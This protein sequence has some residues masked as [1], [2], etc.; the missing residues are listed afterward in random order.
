LTRNRMAFGALYITCLAA[1]LPLSLAQAPAQGALIPAYGIAVDGANNNTP[2]RERR[3][4]PPPHWSTTH[5]FPAGLVTRPDGCVR[6]N[7]SVTCALEAEA[8]APGI[9]AHG[10]IQVEGCADP[11]FNGAFEIE[12]VSDK[13]NVRWSQAEANGKSSSCRLSGIRGP[14]P[15]K[16]GATYPDPVFGSPVTYVKRSSNLVSY[17]TFATENLDHTRYFLVQ[18]G[19]GVFQ[20]YDARNQ[21]RICDMRVGEGASP[22]WSRTDPNTIYFA[23][24]NELRRMNA[25]DCSSRML[26][27]FDGQAIFSIGG[28]AGDLVL[29]DDGKTEY[30]PGRV[31]ARGQYNCEG[32]SNIFRVEIAKQA[33]KASGPYYKTGLA[34]VSVVD[35]YAVFPD[36]SLLIN[37]AT[38]DDRA[39]PGEFQGLALIRA[40][41]AFERQVLDR[42]Y[43]MTAG[44]DAAGKRAVFIMSGKLGLPGPC[45]GTLAG[46]IKVMAADSSK[47]CLWNLANA[48]EKGDAAL[49]LSGGTLGLSGN[50]LA[51][52]MDDSVIARGDAALPPNWLA[53][54]D[55]GAME[56]ILCK[57]DGSVCYRMA[58]VGGTIR[59]RQQL[60]CSPSI[61][62]PEL[63]GSAP[64]YLYCSTAFRQMIGPGENQT[65][66]I[67]ITVR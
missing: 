33:Y 1:W 23:V 54:V 50:W 28:Q 47:S 36:G 39:G 41:G 2:G 32:E 14:V 3:I 31:C 18:P 6:A 52:S 59:Y 16:E 48:S 38:G 58:H 61:A 57:T 24:R 30:L 46:V 40:D 55:R 43:H 49:N 60:H 25:N 20:M 17:S 10:G 64:K 66:T 51:I 37:Y 42:N 67:R 12:N 7:N 11:S 34:G 13:K 22:R 63:P 45:S 5:P 27:R 44:Y 29:A 56:A 65:A 19:P 62:D 4:L 15:E 21:A 26:H 8:P 35:D 53:T 9:F